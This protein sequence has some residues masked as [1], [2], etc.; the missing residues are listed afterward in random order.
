V[1]RDDSRKEPV[2]GGVVVRDSVE[3]IA[4]VNL[5]ALRRLNGENARDLKRYILGL[6]LVAATEPLDGFLRQGCLLVSDEKAPVEWVAV[7][8]DGTRTPVGLTAA[9]AYNYAR[10]AADKFGVGPDRR[11][12]FRKQFAQDDLKDDKKK[13]KKTKDAA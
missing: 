6:S 5:V 10:T 9:I 8:R 4:T 2:L 3:R 1:W 12:T 13:G 7:T 11:V